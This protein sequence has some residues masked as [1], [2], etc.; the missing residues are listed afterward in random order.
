M[1]NAPDGWNEWSK[2]VLKEL[3]SLR[4]SNESIKEDLT[5][6]KVQLATHQVRIGFVAGIFGVLGG[7]LVTIISLLNG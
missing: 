7:A 4:E 2:Y 6:I 1:T 5:E 3:K